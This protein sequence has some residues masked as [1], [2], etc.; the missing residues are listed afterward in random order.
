VRLLVAELR[1]SEDQSNLR[2]HCFAIA[3][4]AFAEIVCVAIGEDAA[5]A[6]PSPLVSEAGDD[7]DCAFQVSSSSA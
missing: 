1:V 3:R 2:C 4:I 7:R 5:I 6:H